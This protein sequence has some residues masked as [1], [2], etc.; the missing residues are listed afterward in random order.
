MTAVTFG[1][2]ELSSTDPSYTFPL[3]TSNSL[4]IKCFLKPWWTQI[5]DTKSIQF[6][7]FDWRWGTNQQI[8]NLGTESSI[9]G[10]VRTGT[11]HL[12]GL[13]S[14]LHLRSQLLYILDV[15]SYVTYLTTLSPISLIANG[16]SKFKELM[17]YKVPMSV[18]ELK[19]ALLLL[20]L[21]LLLL[22]SQICHYIVIVSGYITWL[23]RAFVSF[24]IKLRNLSDDV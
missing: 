7:G 11:K 4:A 15:W 2:V 13:E 20:L 24:P 16:T 6:Q 1:S 3:L 14:N 5:W 19:L 10:K 21:L 9:T 22:S 8:G 23:F 18:S 12:Q 17:K